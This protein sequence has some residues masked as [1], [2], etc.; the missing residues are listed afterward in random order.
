MPGP[1]A[2]LARATTRAA[3][4]QTYFTIRLL[5]N[6]AR[7]DAAFRAYAYFRWVDDILDGDATPATRRRFAERQASLLDQ[8]LRGEPPAALS[9]HEAMLADLVETADLTEW[10]LNAY[11]RNMMEVMTFDASRRGGLVS[12]AELDAYTGWLATAVTGAMHYFLGGSRDTPRDPAAFRAAI[13]AHILHMLRDTGEDLPNGYVNVPCELLD[14]YGAR[15][16]DTESDAYRDWV[17][18]RVRVAAADLEAGGTYF[19][20]LPNLRHRLAGLAYIARFQ[21]LVRRIEADGFR[22]RS[23]YKERRRLPR[24]LGMGREVG[25][26]LFRSAFSGWPPSLAIPLRRPS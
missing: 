21:W 7:R 14:A 12:R 18:H 2:A 5:V 20:H 11:L 15:P 24:V 19:S 25:S 8:C 17:A 23:T 3:S 1:T 4:T 26:L 10:G 22:L 16:T 6:R 13:G 9:R